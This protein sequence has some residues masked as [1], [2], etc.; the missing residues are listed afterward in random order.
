MKQLKWGFLILLILLLSACAT[1]RYTIS[2]II[3]D[4]EIPQL[5]QQEGLIKVDEFLSPEAPF[6]YYFSGWYLDASFSTLASDFTINQDTTVYGYFGLTEESSALETIDLPS[7]IGESINLPKKAGPYNLMWESLD[8]NYLSNDGVYHNT[9]LED[10]EVTLRAKIPNTLY[11]K[12]FKITVLSYP[13]AEK[14][15]EVIN[16]IS[17]SSITKNIILPTKYGLFTAS[18]TSNKPLII[19]EDGVV[20]LTSNVEEVVLTLSLTYL[21]YTKTATFTVN[22]VVKVLS[23]QDS[24]YFAKRVNALGLNE[25]DVYFSNSAINSFNQTVLASTKT[26]TVKL[27]DIPATITKAN[28][29]LMIEKYSNINSY[30]IYNNTTK[31]AI[32]ASEKT[33]ILNNRN[34]DILNNPKLNAISST[35]NIRYGISVN[36]TNLRSYPTNYY[37][38]T[39]EMDRFQETGFGAGIPLVIYHTSLDGQWLFVRM[40]NYAGW[41]EAINVGI[42]SREVFLNFVNPSTFIVIIAPILQVNDAYIRMGTTLPLN[43]TD[44]VLF[45]TRN[46]QGD[47]VLINSSFAEGTFNRGYLD[48]TY[49]NLFNQAYKFLGY[50]YSWGDKLIAGLDCSSTQGAI[51]GCFG[52][53]LGRNTSNQWTTNIY[54]QAVSNPTVASLSQYKPGTLL[55]TSSHVLMYLGVDEAGDAWVLHNTSDGNKCKLQTLKSYSNLNGINNVLIINTP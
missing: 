20:N 26:N 49:S 50:S 19:S 5:I 48:L 38:S 47:L 22:T 15:T 53:K 6:G 8:N 39:N 17:F 24:I 55:Y 13:V 36:H 33:D 14:A 9:T 23:V 29:S 52:I 45:P 46:L 2:F 44:Q 42:C 30:T 11:Y 51:Y 28:L 21:T 40:Y 7:R 1:K 18:W 37:A 12:D 3:E 16:S 27:E 43:E 41:V 35:V 25:N 32:S 10:Y 54:G 4:E 31:K 34:L